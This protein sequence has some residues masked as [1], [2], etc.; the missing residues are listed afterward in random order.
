MTFLKRYSFLLVFLL[1]FILRAGWLNLFPVALTHDELNY[2]INAKSLFVTGQNIPLTSSALFS[3]GETN[4]D[5]VI[6]EMPSVLISPLIGLLPFSQF[7]AR[8]PFATISSL[9]VLLIFL[10]V[11]SLTKRKIIALLSSLTMALNPWSIHFGRT[12]FEINFAVFFFL[13]GIYFFICKDGWKILLSFPFFVFG[14]LSYLGFK[15]LFLPLIIILILWKFFIIGRKE[16]KP[17]LVLLGLSIVVLIVYAATIKY[18]PAGSRTNE[19]IFSD[20]NRA[21]SV[22]DDERRQSVD[23]DL[24]AVFSNKA[25]YFLKRI[26]RSYLYAYSTDLLFLYGETRGAYSFWYHGLLYYVDF[27]LII[28]GVIGLFV[29]NRKAIW[30][31]LSIIAIAPLPSVMG[32]VEQSYVIRSGLMFPFLAA[33]SG[34]GIWFLISRIPKLRVIPIAIISVFYLVSVLNF[35]NLY[36]F[37]YPVYGAEGFFF[38][39]KI[40]SQYI[41]LSSHK[42]PGNKII[43]VTKEPKIVFEE[44]LFYNNLYSGKNN[45]EDLNIKISSK[46]F[47]YKN[48]S[49][50]NECVIS[51][52]DNI[53]V[54]YQVEQKCEFV[55]DPQAKIMALKDSGTIFNITRDRLC[56][57]YRLNNYLRVYNLHEFDMAKMDEENFCITW[58]TK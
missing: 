20:L 3:L 53:S 57:G 30:L 44:F 48:V 22:V 29:V 13:L 32:I 52:E 5:V 54:I 24:Q 41:N 55:N 50:T 14:F 15:L 19:L 38:S 58:I 18:Q 56:E 9:S 26:A 34:I 47:S 10:I 17:L 6:A 37:R 28:L 7:S 43:V 25:T 49:F 23:N 4:Y 2:I 46:D 27:P 42:Y 11:N 36:F 8:L 21:T 35:L 40:L 1:A 31:I 51:N 33:L 16:M 12:A 39:E 45:I